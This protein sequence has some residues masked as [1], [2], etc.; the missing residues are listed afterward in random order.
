[1]SDLWLPL[2]VL[3][4][5]C[6]LLVV[7]AYVGYPVLAWWLARRARR[8]GPA[9]RS[10]AD[11]P[12]VTLVIAA[13]NEE[14]VIARR[15]ENVLASQYPAD[16]L[17]VVVA[18]DGSTDRTH[19]IV[20]GYA[21]RGVRLLAY[22]PRGKAATLNEA[23]ADLARDGRADPAD[24]VVFADARQTWAPDA[25]RRLSENFAD[26]AVG[27]VSGDLV[28]ESAPGVLAG[29]GAYWRYEKWLRGQES[30]AG[31]TVGV[32]GSICAVRRHLYRPI[33][34]GTILDDVYWPLRVAMQG[35]RV[36]HEERA[37]AFDRLPPR[38]GDEFRRKVRTLSGNFQL[39]ARL[40]AALLPWRN[41]VWLQLLSHKVCRLLVP[42]A[43]IGLL[44][45]SAILPGTLYT[46]A[47]WGQLFFYGVAVVGLSR[48]LGG[49]LRLVPAA[50][51]FL[52]LNAAAWLAWWTWLSGS[53][54]RSWVKVRYAGG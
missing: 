30:R 54:T 16:R 25:L 11:A 41:P 43:L 32:S 52:V 8:T 19:A 50:G 2:A 18:S 38:V 20:G 3:F 31:S 49:R 29:V 47:L 35:Y 48:R 28:I 6:A 34:P 44:L 40:P 9:A 26:P 46:A 45:L 33:P 13:H 21:D 4:W 5:A 15:L 1:M 51:A 36:V 7:Y 24:V 23:L 22:P 42:W 12:P 53:S 27:A 37:V 17:R 14:A 10:D 39:I